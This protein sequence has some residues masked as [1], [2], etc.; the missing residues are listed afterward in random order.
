MRQPTVGEA[1][2]A[3]DRGRART[4]DP[5]RRTRLLH[6]ARARAVAV[7]PFVLERVDEH[8]KLLV[9]EL[10][11]PVEVDTETLELRLDVA[12]ADPHDGAA[13][14]Q[15]VERRELL[16]GDER[17]T[18]G[19]HVRVREQVGVG[20][21]G[22]HPRQRADAVLPE[23]AHPRRVVLGERDVVAHADV[24]VPVLVGLPGDAGEL[25][26]AGVALPVGCDHQ[27]LGLDRQLHPVDAGARRDLDHRRRH[28][29]SMMVT[30]AWPPPSHIVWRP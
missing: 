18:V 20:C 10:A 1:R 27:A 3:T 4:G 29:R 26:D 30:L 14:R 6:R 2:G 7:D 11:A 12:G 25:G 16:G 9:D 5:H 21:H 28:R 22:C 23:R 19:E 13:T 8:G 24:V 15:V 17:V